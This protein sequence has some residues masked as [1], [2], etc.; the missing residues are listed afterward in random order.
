MKPTSIPR[1]L[2]LLTSH[3]EDCLRLCLE[4]LERYTPLGFF[5]KI[6]ILAN[7]VTASHAAIIKN[8]VRRHPQACFVDVRPRGLRSVSLAQNEIHKNF[9]LVQVVKLDEDVFVT[10]KWLD[11]LL[12]AYHTYCMKTRTLLA[13]PVIANNQIGHGYILPY[14]EQSYPDFRPKDLIFDAHRTGPIHKSPAYGVWIWQKILAGGFEQS[15]LQNHRNN[16]AQKFSGALNINCIMYDQRLIRLVGGYT[17]H[18]EHEINETMKAKNVWGVVAPSSMVHHYSFGPQ[19]QSID[20][21]VGMAAVAAH[22][23]SLE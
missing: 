11:G 19:Q 23:R 2:M 16:K 22:M 18:D 17:S 8:F 21:H 1:V 9:D 12:H 3:R 5:S 10:P 15:I 20:E 4:C 6:F 14:I 7:E 13:T